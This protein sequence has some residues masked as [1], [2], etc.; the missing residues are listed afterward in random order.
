MTA[1]DP[2]APLKALLAQTERERD[3][4]RAE[5]QRADAAHQAA[6]RQ[7]EQLVGYRRDYE[8]RW[9]EQ[10][11]RLATMDVLHCYQGFIVRLSQA[12]DQQQRVVELA[13][14]R[15]DRERARLAE[16]EMRVLSVRRLIERRA[17]DIRR[18]LDVLEQK[19]TDEFAS[20]RAWQQ[21]GSLAAAL[22]A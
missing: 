6:L 12:V 14:A 8:Q 11:G 1:L 19:Q 3:A 20:R 2:L 21:R 10:F 18:G 16:Q 17:A 13:A 5:C 7:S 9:G 15:A 22:Q 4:V